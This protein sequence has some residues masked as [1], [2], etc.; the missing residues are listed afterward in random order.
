MNV[1]WP[2]GILTSNSAGMGE[3]LGSRQRGVN[4]ICHHS[5]LPGCGT[6]RHTRVVQRHVLQEGGALKSTFK[7]A[8]LRYSL[9]GMHCALPPIAPLPQLQCFT[10]PA[11]SL[12]S[13]TPES[14]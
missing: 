11:Q 1:Q 13:M 2:G 12:Q 6:Q 8:W 9:P 14:A 7:R 10:P 5:S 3:L 4:Q